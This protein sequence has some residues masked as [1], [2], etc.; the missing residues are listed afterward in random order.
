MLIMLLQTSQTVSEQSSHSTLP[1]VLG[2]L[3]GIGSV[4][5]W[6][7]RA[8]IIAK[9]KKASHSCDKTDKRQTPI[10]EH[11]KPQEYSPEVDIKSIVVYFR[12][13][14]GT[15]TSI[16]DDNEID[17]GKDTFDNIDNIIKG[18]GSSSLNDWFSKFSEDRNNWDASILKSK[19]AYL[20]NVLKSCGITCSS[21]NK[22]LWNEEKAKLYRKIGKIEDGQ[23]CTVLS[24]YWIYE[25]DIFEKGVAKISE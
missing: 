15:L 14:M 4:Y 12:G 11:Q 6:N 25:N 13:I 23:E 21:E 18:H 22:I 1:F 16:I 3:V 10:L 17:L 2:V 9:V 20:L 7:H 5:L 19:A 8:E 24:C